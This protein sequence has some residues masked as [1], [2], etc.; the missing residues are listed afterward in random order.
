MTPFLLLLAVKASFFLPGTCTGRRWSS[1]L[2][3]VSGKVPVSRW[4]FQIFIFLWKQRAVSSLTSLKVYK[5]ETKTSGRA[6]LC[7]L[8]VVTHPGSAWC[9]RCWSL[10]EFW[11]SYSKSWS[12]TL[13]VIPGLGL[14]YV[15][16]SPICQDCGGHLQVSGTMVIGAKLS[17]KAHQPRRVKFPRVCE[18]SYPFITFCSKYISLTIPPAAHTI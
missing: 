17:R 11:V 6:Q 10:V 7:H 4:K 1:S 8:A 5:S 14:W 16:N 9:C 3:T 2:I 12:F 13:T 15:H 18:P